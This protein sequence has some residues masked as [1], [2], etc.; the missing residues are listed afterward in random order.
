MNSKNLLPLSAI[1]LTFG[2]LSGN[3]LAQNLVIG[4]GRS[5]MGG[6]DASFI[7]SAAKQEAIR[8]A[9]VKAIKDAT[10]LDASNPKY[11]SI[12]NEVAKQIR[13]L[14]VK[15]ETREGNDFVTRIE[16]NVDRRQIKNAIRGTELDK[17]SDRSFSILM[18]VDEF[19]TSSRDLKMPLRE[20]TEYSYDAGSS[21]RDKSLKADASSSSSRFAY[22][23]NSNVNAAR[24]S[25]TSVSGSS[26]SAAAVRAADGYGGS[27]SG[28]AASQREFN[29]QSASA[30]T[31]KA[32]NNVAAAAS[33]QRA[34]S[35]VDKKDIDEKSHVNESFRKLVE[36]QDNSKP[37]SESIFLSAFS[38]N[39][40]DYDLR[41]QDSSIARSKFFG[42]KKITLAAL[43]NSSDMAKFAEFARKANSDFLMLGT[44]TV[45]DGGVNPATGM[46][47]C[48][49]TAEIKAFAT[50]GS[51]VIAAT[52]EST[53]AAGQNI[54]ACAG[55]ASKKIA[56]MIAPEFANRALGYWADRSAR[57]RQYTV[58]LKGAGI[59][60]PMRLSFA[61]SL[62]D[63]AGATDVEKKEDSDDGVKVTL[64]LK[65]KGDAMEEVYGAVSSQPAF[66]GK[67][68]DGK[69]EGEMITLCLNKC[70]TGTSSEAGAPVKGK[71]K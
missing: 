69:V 49:V 68:L 7:R 41:L 20:V 1:V 18:L 8:D 36:Y 11:A 23:A 57:G 9:V 6:G 53:E 30:A 47:T 66:S 33:S 43:S 35:S 70:V 12:V 40:R 58:E 39:L 54:E 19:L 26:S 28:A 48:V 16:V 52:T 21:F 29:G 25:S 60:L 42:D 15:E 32:S 31:Y 67:N 4:E 27:A 46:V 37:R 65:G 44:S 14:K 62:R 13:D 10:A 38:G 5:P 24:A 17:L 34:S 55:I 45:I 71:K 59:P 3:A 63:I 50:A 56:D 51:E 2:L 61:K 64:T 22:A